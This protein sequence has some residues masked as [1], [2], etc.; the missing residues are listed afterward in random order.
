MPCERSMCELN[1]LVQAESAAEVA[2]GTALL[3]RH[4][5][6]KQIGLGDAPLAPGV[7]GR[8]SKNRQHHRQAA[9]APLN[10]A[11]AVSKEERSVPRQSAEGAVF[12]PLELCEEH[13]D[14]IST[15]RAHVLHSVW[16][17]SAASTLINAEQGLRTVNSCRPRGES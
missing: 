5:I 10:F 2:L 3:R 11:A 9:P 12:L 13:V 15:A 6:R 16:R 8:C 17:V 7:S 1:A 4:A 14:R